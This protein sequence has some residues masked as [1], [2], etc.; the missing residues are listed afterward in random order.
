VHQAVDVGAFAQL[1][2]HVRQRRSQFLFLVGPQVL[3]DQKHPLVARHPI[4][5]KGSTHVKGS[6]LF[7]EVIRFQVKLAD[8][9]DQVGQVKAQTRLQKTTI[10]NHR[11]IS[12]K[13]K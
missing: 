6:S 12:I 5:R 8:D 1:A 11:S 3:P 7:E 9:I 2:D 13:I 10:D 4:D